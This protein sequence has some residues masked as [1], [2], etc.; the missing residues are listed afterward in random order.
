[1]RRAERHG[2]V[3]GASHVVSSRIFTY[4]SCCGERCPVRAIRQ[5][6]KVGGPCQRRDGGRK[7]RRS[8]GKRKGLM[9]K[10][11][12]RSSDLRVSIQREEGSKSGE[13]KEEGGE[14][15]DGQKPCSLLPTT[16]ASVTVTRAAVT[17]HAAPQRVSQEAQYAGAPSPGASRRYSI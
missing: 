6:E 1:M 13:L 7:E 8:G 3:G 15:G 17:R 10:C 5:P 4:I 12:C 14:D 16:P 11:H 2:V 9:N